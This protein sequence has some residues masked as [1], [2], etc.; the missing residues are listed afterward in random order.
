VSQR[1]TY[2]YACLGTAR[3]ASDETDGEARPTVSMMLAMVADH[4]HRETVGALV[5]DER[6][7]GALLREGGVAPM[8]ALLRS[9]A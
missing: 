8:S 3:Q 7:S 1:G 2:L 5:G 9:G 6:R 4:H